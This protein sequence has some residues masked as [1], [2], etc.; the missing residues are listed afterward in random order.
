MN[1]APD[2]PQEMLAKPG[3]TDTV[4]ITMTARF[5]SQKNQQQLIRVA[6][7][8]TGNFVICLIGDGPLI[9]KCKTLARDCGVSDK[10]IFIGTR[11][12]VPAQLASSHIGVLTSNY[13]GLPISLIEQLRAGLPVVASRV[14]GV[15]ELIDEGVNGHLIKPD[16]DEALTSRLQELIDNPEKR[17]AMGKAGRSKY[18]DGLHVDRFLGGTLNV[19]ES[20]V[21]AAVETAPVETAA[22]QTPVT[23][24][25]V[26][27]T[28]VTQTSV[29]QTS[30]TQ[31]SVTQTPV[32]ETALFDTSIAETVGV[33]TS[34]ADIAPVETVPVETV[35]LADGTHSGSVT[36]LIRNTRRGSGRQVEQS[37]RVTRNA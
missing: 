12:D 33:E 22:A 24:T 31:T 13:E 4:K 20:L 29:T 32:A 28:S 10:V 21:G 11:N 30:V 15:A 8:L 5:S 17:A 16:D 7:K 26:T 36:R 18:V 9:D 6:A 1:G 23:Q 35:E 27:Q 3:A 37:E 19:Y 25:P 14:G 34:A 2:V